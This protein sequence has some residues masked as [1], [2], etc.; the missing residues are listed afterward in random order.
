MRSLIISLIILNCFIFIQTEETTTIYPSA[1]V[2]S[3]DNIEND[4]INE[5]IEIRNSIAN[6]SFF[7]IAAVVE[8]N[9]KLTT[10]NSQRRLSTTTN[11]PK[12]SVYALINAKKQTKKTKAG[13]FKEK[14]LI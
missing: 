11:K 14:K 1:N 8:N 13:K 7:T 2:E 3:I 9:P 5:N 4:L 6:K 12:L 10:E